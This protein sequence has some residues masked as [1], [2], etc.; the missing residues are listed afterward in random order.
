V[1]HADLDGV[2]RVLHLLCDFSWPLETFAATLLA[3][4]ITQYP[5]F[6]SNS[7]S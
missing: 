2:S 7:V 5:G 1:I 6:L 4:E 3:I